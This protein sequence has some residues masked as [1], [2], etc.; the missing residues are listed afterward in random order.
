MVTIG[1][2]IVDI[3]IPM[4]V[5]SMQMQSSLNQLKVGFKCAGYRSENNI[6][7]SNIFRALYRVTRVSESLSK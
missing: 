5:R 2:R 3:S 4:C 7:F 1:M 6:K